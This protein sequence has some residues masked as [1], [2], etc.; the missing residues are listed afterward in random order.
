MAR[1]DIECPG[2]TRPYRCSVYSRSERTEL[3]W[4]VTIPGEMPIN[5]TYS[6]YTNDMATLNSYITTVVTGF[7]SREFIHSTLEVTLHEETADSI[8]LECSNQ[9]AND[10]AH[11]PIIRSH[12]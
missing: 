6:N 12:R 3:T 7:S 4:I 10:S 1:E 5:I 9:N 8:L 2:D 11:F